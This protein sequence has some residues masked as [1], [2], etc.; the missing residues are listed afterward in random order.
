MRNASTYQNSSSQCC[1]QICEG[2]KLFQII[3]FSLDP[4]IPASTAIG[5]S[6]LQQP[7]SLFECATLGIVHLRRWSTLYDWIVEKNSNDL[8]R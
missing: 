4:P 3:N 5:L 2:I 8:I 7:F 1:V 6:E